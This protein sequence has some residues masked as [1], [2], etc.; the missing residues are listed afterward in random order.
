TFDKANADAPARHNTQ[1]FEMFG[2][3][4][5]YHDGWMLSAVPQ[6]APWETVGAVTQDP[7]HA[8]KFQLYDVRNDW[9][10]NHDVSAEHPD[11]VKELHDRMFAEFKKYEVFPLDASAATRLVTPRP[12][13]TAG[14][15]VF[16]YSGEPMVGI[17]DST[18][19]RLLN[20]SYT[21]T[22]DIDIPKGGAE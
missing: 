1:Y 13:L 19:P 10:Q 6:R 22:A 4:G 7:A 8:F 2:V 17:P 3:Q 20:T 18:A 12:S 14:R 9:T 5:L 21:I 16:T 11:K 15:Q